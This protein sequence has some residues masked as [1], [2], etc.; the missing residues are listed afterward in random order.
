MLMLKPLFNVI[1][2]PKLS[3]QFISHRVLRWALC[4][5]CLLLMFISNFLLI[6][7]SEDRLF[8]YLFLA[9]VIFYLLAVI[10][11]ML[12]SSGVKNKIL[13]VPYYF[14]FMNVSV[15]LGLYRILTK[16]QSVLWEKAGRL[17]LH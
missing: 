2:Y 1:K 12:A 11:W 8:T 16:K 4:P 10:G 17:T 15:F 6:I 13:Y 9:E 5:F 14:L 7:I 3:F